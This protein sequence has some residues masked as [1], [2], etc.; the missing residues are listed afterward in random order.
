MAACLG[1]LIDNDLLQHI[2]LVPSIELIFGLILV[3]MMLF[4]RQGLIPATRRG[5][6]ADASTSS[7]PR[8][9]AAAS[10]I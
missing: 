8:S 4:R 1:R 2:D 3:C 10:P 6:G 7:M 5:A 9:G